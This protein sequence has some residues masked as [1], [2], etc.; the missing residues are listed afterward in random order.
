MT[1]TQIDVSISESRQNAFPDAEHLWFWFMSGRM[2]KNDLRRG[3]GPGFRPCELIDV[4]ILITRMYLSGRL[5]AAELE[6]LK[7]YGQLRR[8]PSRHAFDE[9]KDAFAWGSAM[10]AIGDAARAKGWV[11]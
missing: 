3:G 1:K 10:K 5:T 8:C 2:I 9:N 6:V 11:E 7:K 4:E